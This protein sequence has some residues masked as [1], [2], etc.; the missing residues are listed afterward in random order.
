MMT[1]RRAV[2]WG[3]LLSAIW[4]AGALLVSYRVGAAAENALA[5]QEARSVGES[6]DA[7]QRPAR[8]ATRYV[9]VAG[10]IQQ[11]VRVMTRLVGPAAERM[12]EEERVLVWRTL[13]ERYISV[14]VKD[15]DAWDIVGAVVV[16]ANPVSIPWIVW[17]AVFG[18]GLLAAALLRRGMRLA[19]TDRETAP[20][21]LVADGIAVLAIGTAVSALLLRGH[22][23]D[24]ALRLPEVTAQT[25][26]DPMVLTLP[27]GRVVALLLAGLW[28]VCTV[29]LVGVAWL[30]S[31]RQSVATRRTARTAWAFLAPSALHLLCFTLGP[32]AF[33][34][35]L[36]VH[37]WDL[38]EIDRPFIG[39]ANYAELVRDPLFWKALRNTALYSLYVPVT[40]VL[41]LGAAVLLNQPLRGIRVLRAMVFLPAIV[42][43]VA[44]A[45]VWQ[46]IYHADYGLLNHVLRSL[47]ASG[48]DWLGD[49]AT[50]LPALMVVSVWVQLGYQMVVYLA[51]LQGVPA[52]LLEAARLDGANAWTRF[53]QVTVP[54][55]RPVSLYLLVTGIIWSFQVFALVYVMTEGG[56]T[57]ATDVLVYQI[58]QNAWEF[59]R[60]GYASALSWVLFALLVGLT[61][62]QWRLLNKRVEHAA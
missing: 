28:A 13:R 58:Y 32:L 27:N 46:W 48:H 60:M 39:L 53:W 25:R 51:G 31:P 47:G 34:A 57:R 3:L 18:S 1:D 8:T 30:A 4:L 35:W 38:L 15:A 2:R 19:A 10:P 54:L 36:S 6:F 45:M 22:L 55:L 16:A 17:L 42:S 52:T 37:R 43:Y 7:T 62:L 40:M 50:A 12:R 59:R 41:A 26:F 49:P 23:E 21:Y 9:P 11:V 61:L 56:P 24:I 5:V 29:G 33:T 14:P 44:I 20:Y